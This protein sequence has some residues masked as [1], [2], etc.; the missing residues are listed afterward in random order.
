MRRFYDDM[1]CER[2]IPART[3]SNSVSVLDVGKFSHMA[4][5]TIS[6]VGA[7]SYKPTLAPV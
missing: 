5:F 2:S 6:L 3:A 7:L 1:D 4:C